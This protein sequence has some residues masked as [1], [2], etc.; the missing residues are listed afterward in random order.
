MSLGPP[1]KTIRAK[2]R[3]AAAALL[4]CL[5]VALGACTSAEQPCTACHRQRPIP[6]GGVVSFGVLGS[7]ATIDPYSPIAS[8]L[9]REVVAPLYLPLFRFDPD[10][11]VE[12]V[13]AARVAK[14]SSGLVVSLKRKRWSDGARVDARDVVATAKRARAPGGLGDAASVR[15]LDRH[16]VVI[17]GVTRRSLATGSF[18]LP[19]GRAQGPGG[20]FDGPFV[21]RRWVRGL[22]LDYVA[23]RK[24]TERVHLDRL[25]VFSVESVDEMLALLKEGRLDAAQTPSAVNLPDRLSTLGL[26]HRGRLGWGSIRLDLS[27]VGSRSTRLAIAGR[28]DRAPIQEGLVRAGGR[29]SNTL[30]PAPGAKGAAGPFGSLPVATPK[31][32]GLRLAVP[33]GDEQLEQI[34]RI[35]RRQLSGAGIHSELVMVEPQTLYGRWRDGGSAGA[36][37][38]RVAGTP[39]VDSAPGPARSAL[40]LPL[41]QVADYL[42]WHPGIGGLRVNPTV[43]GPLYDTGDWFQV[44]REAGPI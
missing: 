35:L 29:V 40:A 24:T 32:A 34:A 6:V 18:V 37:L 28:I 2:R 36:V 3:R 41:F 14:R 43:A 17:R 21:L 26:R 27:G 38:E 23:N 31:G 8:D 15:A 30:D 39:G 1:S 20:V 5:S 19:G 4:V 33:S 13:L 11:S 7:P 12:P 16:R 44:R 22:R 10:G 9:T 42:A 25:T